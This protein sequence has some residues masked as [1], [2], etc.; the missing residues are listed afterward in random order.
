MRVKFSSTIS[1]SIVEGLNAKSARVFFYHISINPEGLNA[2][3]AVKLE[4]IIALEGLTTQITV[5]MKII[6]SIV[7]MK[8]LV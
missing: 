6:S 2:K 3:S 1:A 5:N 7:G 4:I 8:Y